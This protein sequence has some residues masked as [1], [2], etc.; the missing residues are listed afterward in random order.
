MTKLKCRPKK[1]PQKK[2][3]KKIHKRISS[4]KSD[5]MATGK[6]H[7]LITVIKCKLESKSSGDFHC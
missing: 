2:K 6:K 1:L 4:Y 3:K 5:K 7:S